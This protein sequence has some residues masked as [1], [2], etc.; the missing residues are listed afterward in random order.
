MLYLFLRR[1]P[2]VVEEKEQLQL[3]RP[4]NQLPAKILPLPQR[5]GTGLKKVGS[6]AAR[7]VWHFMLEAKDLKQSQILAS[8]FARM[9]APVK[10]FANAAVAN[11][12]G[13]AERLISEG[14]Y[15]QAEE[16]L[17]KVIA[18]YPHEYHA[19]ESLVKIYIKQNNYQNLFEVLEYLIKHVPE[20][21]NYLAQMGNVLM[22][23]DRYTEA[24]EMYE[25]A[26][27]INGLLPLRFIN[28]GLCYQALGELG[29]ARQNFQKALDLEPGNHSSLMLLVEALISL[30]EKEQA[31]KMLADALESNPG[32]ALLKEKLL[33]LQN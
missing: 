14:K 25:R 28:N 32:N 27:A 13:K 17:F 21:D 10:N 8:K 9:V 30:D 22:F 31:L 19:Y 33:Q 15:E 6:K 26:I 2:E 18:K 23:T 5:V 4:A 29:K 24:T 1:V 3:D 20:N 16:T 7:S 12:V 11:T